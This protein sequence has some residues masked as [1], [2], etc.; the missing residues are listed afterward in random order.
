MASYVI[1][2]NGVMTIIG[3]CKVVE[4]NFIKEEDK[5]EI[6]KII[7]PEGV[8]EIENNTFQCLKNLSS[9][10]LPNSL[11]KIGASAFSYCKKLENVKFGSDLE[12]I[13]EGVFAGTNLKIID[14]P[15]SVEKIGLFAFKNANL[16]R[17]KLPKSLKV[18]DSW[19]FIGNK[20]LSKVE[21]NEGL[22]KMDFCA[23]WECEDLRE[24]V[25][26]ESVKHISEMTMDSFDY[27]HIVLPMTAFM[28]SRPMYSLLKKIRENNSNSGNFR[29]EFLL[30]GKIIN[31]N[32]VKYMSSDG[33]VMVYEYGENGD[34]VI[35][36][37]GEPPLM[38]N[39]KLVY[40]GATKWN[41]L[42]ELRLRYA[43]RILDWNTKYDVLPHK[44]VVVNM[45]KSDI[46]LFYKN[47]NAKN[48]ASI[49]KSCTLTED[50]NK[51][52]LF[53]LAYALGVFSENG[54]ESKDA[55]DFIKENIIGNYDE[56]DIHSKFSGLGVYT[57]KYNPEFAKFF[58]TNF[59]K[60]P[61]FLITYNPMTDDTYNFCSLVYREFNDVLK[62]FPNKKI[63]TRQDNDR[64]TPELAI[65]YFTEKRYD[66]VASEAKDLAK[67]IGRYGYSQEDYKRIEEWFLTGLNI[68]KTEKQ[69]LKASKDFMI[70][71]LNDLQGK[72]QERN[73]ENLVGNVAVNEEP[74]IVEVER[75][76]DLNHFD[77]SKV[78]TYELL[79]KSDAIG[80]VL[81]NMTNC[82]QVLNSAGESCL[83]YGMTEPNSGFVTFRIGD[84]LIG[85]AW[86]WYDEKE[87]T[88][89]LDN[90]EVP[91]KM[92]EIL[93]KDSVMQNQFIDCLIRLKN[94]VQTAMGKDKVNKVTIG[95]GYN[96][97]SK[98]LEQNFKVDRNAKTLTNYD[99]YTDAKNQFV[100]TDKQ[101]EK[102]VDKDVKNER[103]M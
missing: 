103:Q 28:E 74:E 4:R 23:F 53:E 61:N 18:L 35:V 52:S 38:I 95:L 27:D 55:T 77:K 46:D 70:D 6:T 34:A 33:S 49:V 83:K 36:K 68:V 85:Q 94:G 10:E 7:L 2:S 48:W 20:N 24:I 31:A 76:V 67:M 91:T 41:H 58:M 101:Q 80:A 82:C 29:C 90:I 78:I 73:A 22:E 69:K 63:I 88:V 54:K 93:R 5:S 44:S 98:V 50:A 17:V 3:N 42:E 86:V 47:N 12:V 72:M 79:E 40:K 64:L 13:N 84:K 26:P 92:L 32:D 56:F 8:E 96:D 97:I 15:D 39:K 75:L 19:V 65:S 11:K 81:G 87:K 43:N 1:D 14:L 89:C 16:R 99:G 62:A 102:N 45:P 25:V 30:N 37:S 9:V 51:D 66:D 57:T 59:K 100:I 71:V 60:N 21:L